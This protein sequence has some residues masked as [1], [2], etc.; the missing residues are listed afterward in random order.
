MHPRV[1]KSGSPQFVVTGPLSPRQDF[2]VEVSDVP[3]RLPG[4]QGEEF[5]GLMGTDKQE[6]LGSGFLCQGSRKA[7]GTKRVGGSPE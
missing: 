6:P 1:E 7:V 4:P 5:K 2:S 3:L